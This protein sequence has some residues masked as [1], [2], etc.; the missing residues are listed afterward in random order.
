M[1]NDDVEVSEIA[2]FDPGLTERVVGILR[3]IAQRYF[4]SMC[5]GWSRFPPAAR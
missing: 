5:V 3:P 2:K 4:R 1:D